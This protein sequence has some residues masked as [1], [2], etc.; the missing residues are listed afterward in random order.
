[1]RDIILEASNGV[2]ALIMIN[3]NK[4]DLV[5]LGVMVSILD[6][7]SACMKIRESYTMPLAKNRGMVFSAQKLYEIIW[8]EQFAVSYTSHITNKTLR[9]RLN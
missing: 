6:G 7:I 8:N 2:E 3:E 4:F 9:K 5:I 1:M